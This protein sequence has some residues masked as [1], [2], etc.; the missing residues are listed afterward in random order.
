[1]LNII[2]NLLPLGTVLTALQVSLNLPDH[3]PRWHHCDSQGACEEPG[4][5]PSEPASGTRPLNHSAV[6]TTVFFSKNYFSFSEIWFHYLGSFSSLVC[7]KSQSTHFPA[8]SNSAPPNSSARSAAALP[9]VTG[10]RVARAFHFK[11]GSR[12]SLSKN[13]SFKAFPFCWK[14]HGAKAKKI[15]TS[16]RKPAPLK[17]WG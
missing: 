9:A 15:G 3:L 2:E 14:S 8:E 10:R 17:E 5:L 16:G 13:G 11:K 6:L 7:I 12:G 1:M 4:F